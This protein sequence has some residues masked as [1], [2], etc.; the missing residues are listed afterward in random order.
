[1]Q[2]DDATRDREPQTTPLA[3]V[4]VITAHW[5]Q[6]LKDLVFTGFC[7]ADAG[8]TVHDSSPTAGLGQPLHARRELDAVATLRPHCRIIGTARLLSNEC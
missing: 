7:I 6:P 4:G 2:L 8:Q 3:L 1:M 5:A